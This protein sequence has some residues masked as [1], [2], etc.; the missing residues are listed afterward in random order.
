MASRMQSQSVGWLNFLNVIAS[1]FI[2]DIVSR[3][4]KWIE[5]MVHLVLRDLAK[6]QDDKGTV[7]IVT[8]DIS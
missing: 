4:L 3:C 6:S 1:F 7:T 8:V 5:S 2:C